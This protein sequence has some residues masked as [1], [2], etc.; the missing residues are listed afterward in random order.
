MGGADK[1]NLDLISKLDKEKY[2]VTILTT[3]PNSNPWRQEFEEYAT[4]YDMLSAD[5]TYDENYNL[6][7][8]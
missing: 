3:Q 6:N 2:E 1:F 4:V 5:A 8:K 7:I